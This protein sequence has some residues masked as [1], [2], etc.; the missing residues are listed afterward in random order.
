MS[1]YSTGTISVTNGST[2]VTGTDTLWATQISAGD[3]LYIDGLLYEILTVGSNTSLQ[4]RTAYAGTTGSNRTY[5]VIRF[6]S[7]TGV[8]DLALRVQQLTARYEGA[9]DTALSG[10]FASGNAG[11]PGVAASGD[12]DSGLFWPG[13]NILGLATGGAERLRI[14]GYQVG[15]NAPTPSANLHIR[16]PTGVGNIIVDALVPS[17]RAEIVLA[18]AGVSRAAVSWRGTSNPTQPGELRI[19]TLGPGKIRFVTNNENYMWIED[20]GNV[21]I[22]NAAPGYPLDV[23]GIANASMLGVGGVWRAD[24]ST[25]GTDLVLR[26]GMTSSS[27]AVLVLRQAGDTGGYSAQPT[28]VSVAKAG[29]TGRSLNAAGTVNVTGADYAEYERKAP[30]C[31]PVAKGDVIGIDAAGLITDRWANAVHFAVKSTD[32][33]F[34]GGDTWTGNLD[35]QPLAPTRGEE[36]P[37]ADW[38][39]RLAAWEAA[40]V[41]WE[42]DA[43]AERVKWDRVAYAGKVPVN[44]PEGVTAAAGDWLVPAPGPDGEIIATVVADAAITFDQYRRSVGRVRLVGGDGRPVITIKAA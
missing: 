33:S 23:V 29:V 11:A 21:G 4:L 17:Q 40:M 3:A 20:G 13:A 27:S 5:R 35:P 24:A 25:S 26:R 7:N 18:E 15:I 28:A 8:G 44:L 43:E 32:P 37:E 1:W 6:Y 16:E 41:A 2:A 36:E 38:S 30:G 12:P 34:V 22:R 9:L 42:Q 10:R 39:A 31:G 19:G 14:S